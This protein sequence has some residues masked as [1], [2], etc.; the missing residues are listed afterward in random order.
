MS[1]RNG[2]L[3]HPVPFEI[4]SH[5]PESFSDFLPSPL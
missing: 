2:R 3:L 1:V 4:E 5:L